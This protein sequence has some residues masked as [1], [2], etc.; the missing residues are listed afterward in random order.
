MKIAAPFTFTVL[1][2]FSTL[3][4]CQSL[5]RPSLDER[6][7]SSRKF[8]DELPRDCEQ[9]RRSV[10]VVLA[11]EEDPHIHMKDSS[12]HANIHWDPVAEMGAGGLAVALTSDGYLLTAAHVLKKFAY[13]SGYMD[14]RLDLAPARVVRSEFLGDPG[15]EYAVVKV[16][17]PLDNPLTLSSIVSPNTVFCVGCNWGKEAFLVILAGK[18][19]DFSR[20]TVEGSG[21][22]FSTTIPLW[23]G[24]SGGPVFSIGGDLVGINTAFQWGPHRWRIRYDRF[25][26][27][28][29]PI[30]IRKIIDGDRQAHQKPIK[31]ADPTASGS[32]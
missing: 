17:R 9:L 26:W 2:L 8:A 25:F 22:R 1:A 13:V 6:H 32:T 3:T 14:G 29:D 24:D 12:D 7:E 27:S 30:M 23:H 4:G 31:A 11:F 15:E 5:I 28:P 19:N 18:I 10:Y 21:A 16:E 20:Q